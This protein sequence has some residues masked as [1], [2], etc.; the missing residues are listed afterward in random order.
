M[1]VGFISR[2]KRPLW[3]RV[4]VHVWSRLWS[5]IWRR[6]RLVYWFE[7]TKRYWQKHFD[8][9][10]ASIIHCQDVWMA[11]ILAPMAKQNHV[12]LVCTVH[13]PA[14]RHYAE[15]M[16]GGDP[17]TY[18]W[19]DNLERTTWKQVDHFIAV[20]TGQA[21][22]LQS[23]GVE[24][25]RISVI[26]NAIDLEE[27]DECQPKM[28]M[29][30]DLTA[31]VL[32]ARRLAHKNGVEYAIRAAALLGPEY[33][34][35]IAGDGVLRR[36]LRQ[37]A[38][39]LNVADR[40]IFLGDL[41]HNTILDITW[42]SLCCVVPSVPYQG[43]IEATSLSAIE[44]MAC[45]RVVI[46][47]AIGGLTEIISHNE[48]GFLIPPGDPVALAETIQRVKDDSALAERIGAQARRYVRTHLSSDSWFEQ[49][50][51]VYAALT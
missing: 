44:A 30:N 10:N 16:Q 13:G 6:S 46:A 26:Y 14:S 17:T 20:D 27:I 2:L 38:R 37:L 50:M 8:P 36:P 31:T 33:R 48:T 40:C 24:P 7:Q 9:K 49:H 22:I 45:G 15:E 39:R 4:G 11:A 19:I 29:N 32:V 41:D 51:S 12:R 42:K 18:Q 28:A 25:S 23:Q 3:K 43:V 21:M 5:K 1:L 47:S 35:V 34:F